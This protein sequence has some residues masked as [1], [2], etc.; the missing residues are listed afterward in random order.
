[1]QG[2]HSWYKYY[3]DERFRRDDQDD[4]ETDLITFLE[5]SGP[6]G[7]ASPDVVTLSYKWRAFDYEAEAFRTL[8]KPIGGFWIGE[9]RRT[10]GVGH[11]PLPTRGDGAEE[12]VIN[13]VK[14]SLPLFRSPNDR[15]MRTFTR[16]HWNGVRNHYDDEIRSNGYGPIIR[17]RVSS[18]AVIGIALGGSPHR[19]G[20]E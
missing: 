10:D 19:V 4:E 11:C 13:G 14:Y 8:T 12:T 6:P 18:R 2:Y 16:V 15:H 17:S 3:L 5:W 7:D 9:H 1:M 20:A